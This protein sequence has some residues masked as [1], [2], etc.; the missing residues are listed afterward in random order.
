MEQLTKKEAIELSL[1]KW[2]HNAETGCT[3]EE[4]EEWIEKERPELKKLKNR[5]GLCEKYLKYDIKRGSTC[6]RCPLKKLWGHECNDVGSSW[7]EWRREPSTHYRKKWAEWIVEDL[8]KI[9][10]GN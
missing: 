8:T 5:C 1:I 2:E 7:S 4:M 6:S 9:L 3:Y 10:Y